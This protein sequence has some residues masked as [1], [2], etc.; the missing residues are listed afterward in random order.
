GNRS[1]TFSHFDF[2]EILGTGIEIS[3]V[4]SLSLISGIV[5]TKEL[6]VHVKGAVASITFLTVNAPKGVL[7]DGAEKPNLLDCIIENRT[8]PGSGVGIEEVIASRSYPF[9]N[10]H[11]YFTAT[12]NCNQSRAPMLNVDPQFFGGTPFNYHL[13]DGSPLKNA[14]S[15]GGEMGAY[16]NGSF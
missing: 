2:R 4:A 6:G 10:I 8:N 9:N 16:G 13:K 3:D 7:I 14:S 11:G 1:F 12:K 5:E 15:K